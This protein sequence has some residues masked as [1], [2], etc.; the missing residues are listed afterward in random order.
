MYGNIETIECADL[1]KHAD[2]ID[3]AC[4]LDRAEAVVS[5]A[6]ECITAVRKELGTALTTL[7][8]PKS[9]GRRPLKRQSELDL[10]VDVQR[11]SGLGPVLPALEGIRG[12]S[13]TKLWR[14][15]LYY[16][17]L[18]SLREFATGEHQSLK[19]AAWA[20]RNRTRHAGRRMARKTIGRTLLVKGLEFDH[21]IVLN[22][23]SLKE[24]D[25]YVALTRGACSLTILSRRPVLQPRSLK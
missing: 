19:D 15:E 23:D 14:K 25:L 8:A 2:A 10:L 4:G 11:A 3:T 6:V 17:M 24:K 12:M 22:A 1:M 21:C 5:F 9:T 7:R 16:A 20:V 13:G 18:Q